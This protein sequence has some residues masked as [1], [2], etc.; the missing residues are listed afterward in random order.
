VPFKAIDESLEASRSMSS[1]EKLL[2]DEA[3]VVKS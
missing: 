1:S 3:V 2:H